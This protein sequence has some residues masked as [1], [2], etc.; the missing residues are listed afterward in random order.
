MQ[1]REPQAP[2]VSR[3]GPV[4]A[5]GSACALSLIRS[6]RTVST[7]FERLARSHPQRSSDYTA[8]PPSPLFLSP[9]FSHSISPCKLSTY[10]T[11][12]RVEFL[13]LTH[14]CFHGI[15]EYIED[16]VAR[17]NASLLLYM[18][19]YMDVVIQLAAP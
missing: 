1:H 10:H 18:T 9:F 16:F 19:I 7:P 12:T 4:S 8:K 17:I 15:T 6:S 11:L 2:S 13:A 3:A 14:L 5:T